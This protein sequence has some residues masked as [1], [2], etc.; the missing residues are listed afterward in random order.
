MQQPSILPPAARARGR[1]RV[2]VL[3]QL[4]K[5]SQGRLGGRA[6]APLKTMCRGAEGNPTVSSLQ[7]KTEPGPV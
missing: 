6:R 7:S 4:L 1:R 2:C 3:Q 5:E